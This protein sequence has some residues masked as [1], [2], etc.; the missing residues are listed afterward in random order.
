MSQQQSLADQLGWSIT[1]QDYLNNLNMELKSVAQRYQDS[2]DNLRE[3]GYI[4]EMMPH[5]ENLC[6]E[7]EHSIDG[8]VN[9]IENEHIEY[10]DSR[11][12]TIEGILSGL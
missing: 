9:Y 3:F 7:F 10:V 12:K 6:S 4:A 1:T 2:V 11:S 5:L 8:I